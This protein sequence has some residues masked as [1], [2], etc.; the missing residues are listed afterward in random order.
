MAP[1]ILVQETAT[2][3]LHDGWWIR[4]VAPSGRLSRDR[5]GGTHGA[6]FGWERALGVDGRR[7]ERL[8]DLRKA[9]REVRGG[10][11]GAPRLPRQP[12]QGCHCSRRLR[13]LRSL[14]RDGSRRTSPS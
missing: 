13:Q 3:F 1:N 11:A 5:R 9:I 8:H 2:L 14:L 7:C 6:T 12:A 10:G 4:A